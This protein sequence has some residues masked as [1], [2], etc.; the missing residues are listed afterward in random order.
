MIICI[1]LQNQD[2]IFGFMTIYYY[3]INAYT[4]TVFTYMPVYG[5]LQYIRITYCT[6]VQSLAFTRVFKKKTLHPFFV[7]NFHD[8]F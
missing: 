7:R 2:C 6:L 8:E 1:Y 4:Y 3:N 5:M